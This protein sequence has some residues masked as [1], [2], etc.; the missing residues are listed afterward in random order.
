MTMN[1]SSAK[2][3]EQARVNAYATPLDKIDVANGELYEMDIQDPYFERLRKEDPVHH[4][5]ASPFGPYWSITKF[6]D[7]MHVDTNHKIF[8][9]EGNVVI[10]DQL[11]E[12]APGNF[13]SHDPPLHDVQRAAVTPAVSP[14]R[15]S[16]IEAVIR[17]R[18][19]AILDSL[20]QNETFNWVD[21]V[22]VE[23]TTQ[24]LATLFGFPFEERH[25][26]PYWSDVATSSELVG[27]A[28][29][30]ENQR[31]AIMMECL[32]YFGGLWK[33]RAA[34]PPAADFVSLLA[35]NPQTKDMI[36]DPME[37]LGNLILLIIGGNDTTR[38]SISGG[39]LAL[40][41]N[42]E[43]FRKLRADPELIPKMVP[44]IIRWQTPLLH[45]RRTALQDSEL[46]GKLIKKG[47]KVVMWYISGNR[48]DEVIDRP[49]DFI[50]DRPNSRHH[51]SFGF[52]IHR[53]M[54][55]RVA[56]MQLRVLWEEILKRFKKVELMGDPVRIRSNFVR[57]I[58]E[59]PVRVAA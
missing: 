27:N 44:E 29:M 7:I 17:Q 39:V 16:E 37:F 28:T 56:E 42:P 57:G 38:N 49:N 15:L 54:G 40:N 58:T 46:G 24:M 45:M 4:T 11:P 13:I 26:L 3:I 5:A 20:P 59:L 36:N 9:S 51:L 22:S 31:K 18:A 21:L 33:E 14:M 50:I 47:D 19:G 6:K 34:K 10:G 55:N 35:H 53:C 8:S 43:Q 1:S 32:T 25:K 48:D 12:F 2:R 23:L 52:G 30:T 41:Q